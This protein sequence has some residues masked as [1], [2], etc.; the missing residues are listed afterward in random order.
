MSQ[1]RAPL[2]VGGG[3]AGAAAALRLAQHGMRPVLLE[4]TTGAH[5]KMC[6]EFLS[7]EAGAQ[8]AALGVDVRALGGVPIDRVCFQRGTRSAESRL[9]FVATGITRRTLDEALLATCIA[10][11]VDVQRGVRVTSIDAAPC[12]VAEAGPS[13]RRGAL[14]DV[15]VTTNQ[16]ALHAHSVLLATGKHEVHG[17]QRL[18]RGGAST[19]RH[20]LRDNIGVKMYFAATPALQRALVRTV[21]IVGYD[22]GYAGV[23]LVDGG[24][25]NLCLLITPS[26]YKEVGGS[27]EALFAWLVRHPGLSLLADAQPL[28]ER[29]LTISHVPYGYVAPPAPDDPLFRLGDQAAVIPSFCGDGMAIAVHSGVLAADVLRGGGTPHRFQSQLRRDVAGPIRL[30]TR[31]QR[32][33]QQSAG[34]WALI[35][36]VAVMPGVAR[37]LARLTRVADVPSHHIS[38]SRPAIWQR[39]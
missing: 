10:H 16:G 38:H 14:D 23:Q 17:H 7:V 18:E 3:L 34:Q 4:R 39:A 15:A 36:G 8:L 28:L 21:R 20:T 31:L 12:P 22:G 35:A 13:R 29:P 33:T 24:R 27:W 9:P 26:Q 25:V 30:A 37:V 6:G 2:I 19:E 32:M 5:D 11:G 1:S